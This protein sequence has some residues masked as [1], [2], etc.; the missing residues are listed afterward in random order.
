[1]PP[2]SRANDIWH[3]QVRLLTA[4]T[5]QVAGAVRASPGRLVSPGVLAVRDEQ[6][7][8]T[9]G[10]LARDPDGHALLFTDK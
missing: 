6:V 9:N 4:N 2:D 5:D 1:M 7:G 3:W 8:Y 10:L